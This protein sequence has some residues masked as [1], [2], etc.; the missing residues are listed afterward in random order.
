[1]QAASLAQQFERAASLR[2]RWTVLSWLTE[3]LERV[4]RAQQ[5]M[6]FIYP[7]TGFDGSTW[8]YFIH[9]SRTVDAMI[10]PHDEAG[11]KLAAEKKQAIYRSRA[12]LL[13]CY[14]HA[15]SMMLVMLW[16]RQHPKERQRCMIV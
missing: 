3:R 16:F 12:G 13:D 9:G 1:M 2:D 15:D 7:V 5:E 6:S 14:E 10:A 11:H 4:R 8:W